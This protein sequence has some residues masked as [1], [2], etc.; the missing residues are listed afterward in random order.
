MASKLEIA[1][2]RKIAGGEFESF[3]VGPSDLFAIVRDKQSELS[4]VQRR[5]AVLLLEHPQWFVRASVSDIAARLQVSAPTV[6][7]FARKI[8]FEGLRDLKLKL[9]GA[10]ALREPAGN[11]RTVHSD[12]ADGAVAVLAERLTVVLSDWRRRTDRAALEQAAE[13]IHRA[14]Q[15]MCFGGNAFSNLLA[16]RLHGGLY[17]LGYGAHSLSDANYQFAAVTTLTKDDV[18]IVISVDGR[19]PTLVSVVELAKLRGVFIIAIVGNGTGLEE[20]SDVLVTLDASGAPPMLQ[21]IGASLLQTLTIE[22]L[23]ILVGVKRAG[24]PPAAG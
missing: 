2:F 12:G 7:R 4:G 22:A 3:G 10:M 9:A 15:I 23:V 5:V 20:K 24:A 19:H 11:R 16:Q 8:G 18:L 6:V 21:D 17:Q 13:A 14:R 1:E